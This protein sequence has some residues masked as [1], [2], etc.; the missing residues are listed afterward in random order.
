[1]RALRLP[2]TLRNSQFDLRAS[3]GALFLCLHAP[4]V[5]PI[6]VA[7]RLFAIAAQLIFDEYIEEKTH[8]STLGENRLN[9]G[10]PTNPTETLGMFGCKQFELER[11]FQLRS[12]QRR[13]AV[14]QA[15][16]WQLNSLIDRL[17]EKEREIIVR[18]YVED[19]RVEELYEVMGISRATAF[20]RLEAGILRMTD[21]YREMYEKAA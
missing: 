5:A 8:R 10:K 13:L 12:E 19:V 21:L 15:L 14:K 17:D 2:P 11:D 3:F 18:R 7:E 6:S 1:M 4:Q 16:L 20:R 9:S